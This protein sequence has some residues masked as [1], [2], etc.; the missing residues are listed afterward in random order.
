MKER[1]SSPGRQGRPSPYRHEAVA[2]KHY[3]WCS[4]GLSASQPF[5][6][7]SHRGTD[8]KPL[9]FKVPETVT[10][11]LCGCKLTAQPPYCDG[12]HRGADAKGQNA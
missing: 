8:L 3:R 6:D 11:A 7:E 2:G 10:V 5:C 4:C 12:S 1:D 9:S